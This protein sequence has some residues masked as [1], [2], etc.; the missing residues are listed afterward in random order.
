MTSSTPH[1]RITAIDTL[2]GFALLG[3]LTMN[4]ASFSMPEAAYLNPMAYGGTDALNLTVHGFQA[5][6]ADQKFMALF[7]MLFGAGLILLVDKLDA[8]GRS[9]LKIHYSRNVWLLAFGIGHTLLW[10]GD[11]LM[12]YALCAF[13]LYL[14]RGLTAKTQII[15]G[16]CVYLLPVLVSLLFANDLLG[17]A[18]LNNFFSPTQQQLDAEIAAFQ[19]GLSDETYM[20]EFTDPVLLAVFLLL[21]EAFLRAFGMMLIGMGLFRLGVLSAK[22]SPAF[23]R[24]MMIFGFGIGIPLAA[25]GLAY[26]YTQGWRADFL[27]VY[28]RQP[29]HFAALFLAAG[30]VGLIMTWTMTRFLQPLQSALADVGQMALTNYIGQTVIATCI[31]YWYGLGLFGTFDRIAQMGVVLSIWLFQIGLSVLWLKHFK[32]GPL[33]WLWRSLTYMRL[34]PLLRSQSA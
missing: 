4:I 21:L 23:Y 20:P 9:P 27:V 29:N 6:L 18:D 30:Y 5:I 2:R 25:L 16:V 10:E 28:G 13:V 11:V 34:Q 17:A 32:Y 8:T 33:E 3:I 15:A 31:F 24:N 26:N 22:A 14:F 19:Q 12:I 1:S 7:S